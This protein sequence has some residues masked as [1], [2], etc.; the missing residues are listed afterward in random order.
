MKKML[1]VIDGI[2]VLLL[3]AGTFTYEQGDKV[4]VIV[5][6]LLLLAWQMVENGWLRKRFSK[7][8]APDYPAGLFWPMLAFAVVLMVG[9]VD[10]FDGRTLRWPGWNGPL[11]VSMGIWMRI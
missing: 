8:P 9:A 4:T 1:G 10:R 6:V 3:L 11:L 5:T 7:E 2:G